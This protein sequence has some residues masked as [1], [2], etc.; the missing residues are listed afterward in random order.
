MGFARSFK[1]KMR[2]P[3]YMDRVIALGQQLERGKVYIMNIK[4][5]DTCSY[6]INGHCNCHP[7]IEP[8]EMPR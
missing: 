3:S 1:R 5:D 2:T 4:H 6:W 7:D 8:V